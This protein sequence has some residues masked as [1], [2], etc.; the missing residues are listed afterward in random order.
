LESIEQFGDEIALALGSEGYYYNDHF[1]NNH[2]INLLRGYGQQLLA[3]GRF[4]TAGI[5]KDHSF[6]KNKEIRTDSICWIDRNTLPE[7]L[8][9]FYRR[10]D[11]FVAEINRTCYLGIVDSELHL[12]VYPKGTFYKKHLDVFQ[13]TSNRRLSFICYLNEDWKPTDGGQLRLYPQA[14]NEN[15]F[16]DIEPIGGRLLCFMSGDIPHEVLVSQSERWSITGWLKG[17]SYW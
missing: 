4:K 14:S 9:F 6:Q 8:S 16:L 10:F 3:L 11:S 15:L 1:L 13:N 12:A 7:E 17:P 2:E 5:G